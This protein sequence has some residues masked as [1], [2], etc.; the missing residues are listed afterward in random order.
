M[1]LL[2]KAALLDGIKFYRLTNAETTASKFQVH[3]GFPFCFRFYG[4]RR[5]I[6]CFKAQSEALQLKQLGQAR[7]KDPTHDWRVPMST[8]CQGI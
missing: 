7:T 3:V 8:R 1:L 5:P 6:P 2:I 4:R